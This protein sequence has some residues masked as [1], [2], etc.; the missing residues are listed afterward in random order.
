[1]HYSQY[2]HE[3]SEEVHNVNAYVFIPPTTIQ[4]LL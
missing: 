1:M 4:F 3:G 2:Q